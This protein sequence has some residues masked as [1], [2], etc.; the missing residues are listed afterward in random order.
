MPTVIKTRYGMLE[1][2][3]EGPVRVW[4]G[5]PYASPPV[6]ERRLRAPQPPQPWEGIRDAGGFGPV[7]H[8]PPD[9]RGTRFGGESPEH[10]EDCLYLNIWAP[11]EEREPLPVMVWIHGGTFVTGSGSQ[12]QFDGAL[13]AERG[14]AVVV[15][16]NYRLGPFGFLHWAALGD[17]F[18][19]NLGL[20]D[21]IAA[22]EWV[23]G[24]IEAFGGDP[25]RVT[26]FGESAGGMS[27]AAL[28]ACPAAQGLF[29][30]AILQSGAAQTMPASQGEAAAREMLAEL[31]LAPEEAERLREL[32][33]DAIMAAA[34]ALN[35]RIGGPF[36]MLFQP[37]VDGS[38]LPEEPLAAVAAGSSRGV[39]LMVGTNREEGGYFF[40]PGDPQPPVPDA[41]KL[42]GSML[43]TPYSPEQA[44][45]YGSRGEGAPEILTDM[46]FWRG[47]LELS[48][49]SISHA[50]VW[51]Y[52]FDAGVPGHPHFERAV[53][54]AEI[55]FVFGTL[56]E[57]E[58]L[59]GTVGEE[60]RSVSAAMMMAWAAFA[61]SGDP[62]AAGL[63]WPAYEPGDR[64]T[65][66]FGS[67]VRLE[68]DPDAARRRMVLPEMEGNREQ[69]AKG[70]E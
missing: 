34:H 16:L 29:A 42:V 25:A 33:A 43:G 28:L 56:G 14:R 23:Q 44:E 3:K 58:R 1:G 22:L 35:R 47:A 21:M 4:K 45:F 60:H 57:L 20:L 59:G 26:L 10:S 64:A 5:I 52:R 24:S 54:S 41:L 53:H 8:Q 6:G 62:S 9:R 49:R 46:I 19:S 65:L 2:R 31:G 40:R 67:P 27:I 66:I 68:R 17:S 18:D 30:R 48:E 50:P 38:V 70:D 63:E 7:S 11:E 13:L 36:G 69:T 51:M 61:H 12:P 39:P 15:T 55:S 32:P 37:V